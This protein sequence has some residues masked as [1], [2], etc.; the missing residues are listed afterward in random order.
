MRQIRFAALVPCFNVGKACVPVLRQTIAQVAQCVAVDDGS[1]DDTY[2]Y[3]QSLQSE[4]LHLLQ[5]PQNRGKGHALLTGFRFIL[6]Q[7]WEI[8]AILTLDGDGQHDPSLIPE[9]QSLYEMNRYDLIYGN[10]MLNLSGMP[11]HRRM[12]NAFSNWTM[13]RICSQAIADSQCGFRLYSTG[14]LEKVLDQMRTGRYE[15]ETEILIK[16]CRMKSRIASLTIPTIYSEQ[17]AVLSHHSFPDVLRIA[18]LMAF[19]F[20]RHRTRGTP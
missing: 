5:H 7:P 2:R 14:F 3:M 9:F 12:L 18:K 17:S 6:S 4:N 15:F 13:S 19:N 1:S 10:R 8:E 20:F 16:A 11:A